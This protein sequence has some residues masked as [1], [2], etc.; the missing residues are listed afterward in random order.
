MP[1]GERPMRCIDTALSV[2]LSFLE[3]V[4]PRQGARLIMTLGGA[5]TMMS[6]VLEK[7]RNQIR[8][9]LYDAQEFKMPEKSKAPIAGNIIYK[10]VKMDWSG[11]GLQHL[12]SLH[13]DMESSTSV[14]TVSS[15]SKA[16]ISVQ[17]SDSS[18]LLTTKYVPSAL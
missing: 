14:K 3:G 15:L 2:G 18:M 5:A 4:F 16:C 6:E 13:T 1:S 7:N 17:S 12:D 9:Y 10:K 8:N 11:K